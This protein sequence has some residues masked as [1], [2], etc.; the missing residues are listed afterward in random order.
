M[1]CRPL[2]DEQGFSLVEV[3]VAALVLVTGMLAVLT[4]ITEAQSATFS[5]QARSGATALVREVTEGARAVPYEQLVT[6]GLVA[7]LQ[8]QVNLG[9]DDPA[10]PGWQVRRGTLS[11]TVAVGV[12]A[13]DDARDRY[14]NHEAGQFCAS[15]DTGTA[16]A[17]CSSLLRVTALVG[18]PGAGTT[19]GAVAGLGDCG[20]DVD[21]DGA[22][23]GLV[24]AAGSVCVGACAVGGVDPSPADAKRIVVL[25]R[26]DRGQGA[27]YV[28]QA[29]T[30]ANP[31]LAGA[32]AIASLTTSPG[33]TVTSAATTAVQLTAATSASASTVA[34]YLD[35][36]QQGTATGAGTAWTFTWPLGSVSGGT[37]PGATEV[38]DGS[39][40]VGLKAFDANGQFGQSRSVTVLLNRRA[41]YPPVD[42]RV[43]RNG[44]A[45]DLEWQPNPER[46]IATYR[47]YRSSG[48]S[49]TLVC[50]TVATACQ[51]TGAPATGTP[52]YT[53]VAVDRDAA[54]ALRE[55]A[56]ATT[57]TVPLLNTRP[58]PP[59][60]LVATSSA[61][62]TILTWSAPAVADVDPGDSID[63]YIVYRD[64]QQYADRYERTADA[65]PTTWT[66]THVDGQ[67]HT[68]SVTAV[69]T[70]LA[71]STMLGPVTR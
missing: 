13:T 65:T 23:D 6:T 63:H 19:A 59:T 5:T 30:V 9:D 27:R 45:V 17:Q 39:Y 53:V 67:A 61:G 46:D 62:T 29:T 69:D 66:D 49:W 1:D 54:G 56:L 55:G 20:L 44:G 32:P 3:L 22:V 48:G 68:Y 37:T 24:D 16:P 60:A 31:G 40:L 35:G 47:G 15:G 38:V 26:W 28:L 41:P 58:N 8:Q 70:H 14:G 36:T 25:V 57:A 42:L 43:G 34:A 51:D 4:L 52:S 10:T 50:E 2:K 12:C 18:L 7:D 33:S 64:G 21:F 11:Y 71:E